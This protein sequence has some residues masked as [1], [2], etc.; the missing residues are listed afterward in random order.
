MA[1]ERYI[2]SVK[3][4]LS[5]AIETFAALRLYFQFCRLAVSFCVIIVVFCFAELG[6]EKERELG[7]ISILMAPHFKFPNDILHWF[8]GNVKKHGGQE[9]LI[10]SLHALFILNG[11]ITYLLLKFL[12]VDCGVLL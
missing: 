5:K 1:K 7:V 3:P 6:G 10:H 11:K 9:T 12:S 2:S 8:H 4:P